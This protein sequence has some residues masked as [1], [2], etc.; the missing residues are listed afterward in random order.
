MNNKFRKFPDHYI[1]CS[2]P[3]FGFT[4]CTKPGD[5]DD[6]NKTTPLVVGY[7]PFSGKFSPFFATTGY[8]MD[9]AEITRFH[10]WRRIEWAV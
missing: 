2:D 10:P 9:A 5:G 8:D 6:K 7:T 4:A 1:A 3:W